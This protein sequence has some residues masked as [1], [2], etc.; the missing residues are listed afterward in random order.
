[1]NEQ[2][3]VT[4]REDDWS[5]LEKLCSV[6]ESHPTRLSSAETKEFLRLYRLAS[7]DLSII[8]AKST[9]PAL[10]DSLNELVGRAYGVLYQAPRKP[11]LKAVYQGLVT[12]AQTVRRRRAFVFASITLFFVGVFGS[13]LLLTF[14]PDTR[15]FFVP[16][17]MES[18]F[19]MWKT[20]HFPDRTSNDSFGAW[21]MYASNNPL[22][23]IM[24]GSI[25][26]GTFGIAST[27]LI[28]RNGAEVGALAHEVAPLGHLDFLLSSISPHG[29]PEISGLFMSGAAGLLLGYALINPGRRTRGDSLREVG[30][31]AITLLGTSVLLMLI[32]APIEGFFSFN[33]AVP[34]WLKLCVAGTSL[35]AWLSFWCYFGRDTSDRTPES[36]K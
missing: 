19:E 26:A 14:S 18:S 29:V 33:P 10:T 21:G 32:A 17:G 15:S 8:R 1:M 6:A 27:V 16:P 30:P 7:T 9:N 25:G 12:I 28:L 24:T 36:A 5:R 35:L 11:I 34:G 22:V 31:D 13:A 4:R 20:G 23:A 3:F 2:G